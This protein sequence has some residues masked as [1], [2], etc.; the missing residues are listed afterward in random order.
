[1]ANEIKDKL[2]NNIN[3]LVYWVKE[4]TQKGE[5]FLSEQTPLFI[6]E[7][8]NYYTFYIC[9]FYININYFFLCFKKNE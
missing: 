7:V 5:E 2:L 9:F 6:Q 8:I 3:E 4:T 1:M